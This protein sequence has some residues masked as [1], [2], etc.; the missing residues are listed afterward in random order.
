MLAR[1]VRDGSN[2][3][4][5]RLVEG[6][7]NLVY[8][9]ALRQVRDPHLAED[10][11]QAVFIVLAR[12]ARSLHNDA[13]LSG[14]LIR[15]TRFC[16]ADAIKRR[17]RRAHYERNAAAMKPKTSEPANAEM[18]R[19]EL[20]PQLDAA[21][22]RLSAEDRAVLV[23][24]YLDQHSIIEIAAS[25]GIGEAAVRKRVERALEKLRRYF[26]KPAVSA[27]ALAVALEVNAASTSPRTLAASA[28]SAAMGGAAGSTGAAI[29]DGAI[30]MMRWLR[31]K[32]AMAI[33]AA[34]SVTAAAVVVGA[35]LLQAAPARQVQ[36][37]APA[38][39]PAVPASAAAVEEIV[40]QP[41][42]D[43]ATLLPEQRR[44]YELIY[45][46][47]QSTPPLRPDEWIA[48]LKEVTAIG[49]PAVPALVAELNTATRDGHQRLLIMA[50]R[51]IKDPRAV[52]ALFRAIPRVSLVSSDYGIIVTD[53]E[54]RRWLDDHYWNG[55]LVPTPGRDGKPP[56]T[57]NFN[58]GITECIAALEAIT[59]HSEGHAPMSA[60]RGIVQDD[61]PT[62][63]RA[64]APRQQFLTRWQTWWEENRGKFVTDADMNSMKLA[65]YDGDIVNAVGETLQAKIFPTGPNVRLSA[66][67]EIILPDQTTPNAATYLDFD[68]GQ[69]YRR[70]QGIDNPDPNTVRWILDAGVDAYA[71]GAMQGT[72]IIHDETRVPPRTT[73]VSVENPRCTLNM[74]DCKIWRIDNARFDTIEQELREGKILTSAND[75]PS[76][77]IFPGKNDYPLTALFITREGGRGIIQLVETVENGMALKMRYRMWEGIN[78]RP[79]PL[80]AK[81]AA[82][83]APST[84]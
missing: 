73:T 22:C 42:P 14:W 72:L 84:P 26:T 21:L 16:A 80:A 51:I 63:A 82:T 28:V 59:G 69:I 5:A 70:N 66:A 6:H 23:L 49:K 35:I 19:E 33:G 57:S 1:F 47:R 41:L 78:V 10:V 52:P 39:S 18:I 75:R 30:A 53:Q 58:R 81:L 76:S 7:V 46:L 40:F 20:L 4:F 27:S 15:T 56:E 36:A 24:R 67:K 38:S 64:L 71:R 25:L 62:R 11:T 79:P 61:E 37:Q 65:L 44:V 54:L 48:A 45:E 13:T 50:L 3:A 2:D 34:V 32:L 74:N 68:A 12:K 29:A 77:S 43:V 9:A 31:V 55:P 8:A 60:I 17:R 83:S